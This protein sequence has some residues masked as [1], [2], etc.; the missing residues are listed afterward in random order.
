[1]TKSETHDRHLRNNGEKVRAR[2]PRR[3]LGGSWG[4]HPRVSSTC[5]TFIPSAWC[6][7]VGELST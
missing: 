4:D 2:H 1:M 5:A 6:L 3:W 7:V